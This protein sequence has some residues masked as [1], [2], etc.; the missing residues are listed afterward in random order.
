[1]PPKK[2]PGWMPKLF[3]YVTSVEESKNA[4][5]LGKVEKLLTVHW[6]DFIAA[7]EAKKE[8]KSPKPR[9][10]PVASALGTAMKKLSEAT[11]EEREE[12]MTAIAE[13]L[14]E[15]MQKVE[16]EDTHGLC[17]DIVGSITNG[18]GIQNGAG[19]ATDAKTVKK[20]KR[21][22]DKAHKSAHRRLDALEVDGEDAL[23]QNVD[24]LYEMAVG[25]GDVSE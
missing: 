24:V 22:A 11:P 12:R 23:V 9:A 2:F 18:M 15:K 7:E 10:D 13:Q 17:T 6:G 21:N 16:S 5:A 19:A 8:P 4:S 20:R 3:E 25:G 1:M 14:N